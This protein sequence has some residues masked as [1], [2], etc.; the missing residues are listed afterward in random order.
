[1]VM[2]APVAAG[3]AALSMVAAAPVEQTIAKRAAPGQADIDTVILNYALTL[4]NLENAFYRDHLPSKAAFS[5]AGYPSWVHDRL[6]NPIASMKMD[7]C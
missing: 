6:V 1:M 7:P 5:K 2:I 4:E 3:L